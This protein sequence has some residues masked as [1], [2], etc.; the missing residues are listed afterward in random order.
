VENIVSTTMATTSDASNTTDKA[1]I[2]WQC[3]K[4]SIKN[5]ESLS[6]C[7]SCGEPRRTFPA[8]D[9][10]VEDS[11]VIVEKKSKQVASSISDQEGDPYKS[12]KPIVRSNF[13]EHPFIS[14]FTFLLR[15]K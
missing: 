8:S 14:Y 5:E 6:R 3:Q 1:K 2:V 13:F 12:S 7:G 10:S 15:E 9:S 11:S 4:C